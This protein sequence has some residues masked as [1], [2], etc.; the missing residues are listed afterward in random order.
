MLDQLFIIILWLVAVG[1]T[2]T[3]TTKASIPDSSRPSIVYRAD[4]RPPSEIRKSGGFWPAGMTRG[5]FLQLPQNTSLVNHISG[6]DRWT[7][8]NESGYVS[9]TRSFE[10]AVEI[11]LRNHLVPDGFIYEIHATPNF[12]DVEASLL[13]FHQ[14][15]KEEE[16]AA[17]GGIQ[18]YQVVAWRQVAMA[19]TRSGYY[20]VRRTVN[21]EYRSGYFDGA[22]AGG[23]Q[24]QLAGFAA[25]HI[26]FRE[27]LEPWCGA[28]RT[29]AVDD[30]CVLADETPSQTAKRYMALVMRI[31][32]LTVHARV[33]VRS[34]PGATDSILVTVGDGREMM[35]FQDPYPGKSVIVRVD[36]G[37]V[38]RGRDVY[39]D[40]LTNLGLVVRPVPHP[41][42]TKN[43]RIEGIHLT[44]G[45]TFFG[46]KLEM[47]KFKD[48]DREF[49][50]KKVGLTKFWGAEIRLEDWESVE[51]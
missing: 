49:E 22:T 29:K 36:L 7:S 39:V 14:G 19:P 4:S 8:G 9:T 10:V 11:L 18:F 31:S 33:S 38:F 48:M 50:T 32:R 47:N 46:T 6:D 44:I 43:I 34:W 2:A 24:P 3:T 28:D 37:L 42:A 1:S 23:S 40:D 12:I 41:I 20:N 13:N 5:N 26:V 27:R 16:F 51:L 30:R 25:D 45:T 35:L 17:L 21:E 15:R